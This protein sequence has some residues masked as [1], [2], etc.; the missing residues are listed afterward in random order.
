[1]AMRLDP[2]DE[3]IVSCLLDDGRASFSEIGEQVGLSAPAVKRR[4]D[5]LR[6]TGAITG[7][8]VTVDPDVLGWS[9]EAF[10]E[11]HCASRTSPARIRDG[12]A[13]FP[14]VV[15]AC[16]VTGDAD[17]L[18]S[19]RAGD[20]HHFESVLEQINAEPYVVRTKTVL[21]LS[22]LLDRPGLRPAGTDGP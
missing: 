2:L 11:L 6:E 10:V 21:V 14:E 15:S 19:I 8:T 9:T 1:M 16:T 12:V 18:V 13:R 7:F 3:R 4:V 17:A 20:V 22:R 5:R